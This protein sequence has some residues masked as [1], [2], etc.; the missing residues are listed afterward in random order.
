[1]NSL[2]KLASPGEGEL[3]YS[4]E[5]ELVKQN[6]YNIIRD[7][8][9]ARTVGRQLLDVIP[10]KA[11]HSMDFILEDKDS[12]KMRF[13]T[14]GATLTTDVESYTKR[15]ITPVKYGCL[16]T[17]TQEIREDANWNVVARNLRRAGTQAALTED[18]LVFNALNDGTY[19]VSTAT[20]AAGNSHAISSQGTEIS[21]YDI[22]AMMK[23]IE[24]D[25][26]V[27][28]VLVIHPTQ[29]AELRQ[30][31]TFVEADKVGSDITFQKGFVGKIFG[32]D[33][34]RTTKAWVDQT[35]TQYAWCLDAPEVG[36][37]LVRRP[38]TMR[39]FEIPE[40]DVVAGAVTIR[41]EAGVLRAAAG[42]RLTIS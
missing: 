25:D 11:G 18:Y 12:L 24:E 1:M 35:S 9:Y 15:T 16:V 29:T 13:V 22:A 10:V 36:V 17:V 5:T 38:L 39:P 34:I 31:D 23:V 8:M 14:E 27:P 26:Y 4:W 2:E 42:S 28:N 19:G 20:S 21:I 6:L 32:M 40:R 3:M 30:I 33:V 7:A 41:E 37:L